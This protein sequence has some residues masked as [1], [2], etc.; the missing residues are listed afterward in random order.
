MK[1]NDITALHGMTVG[2]LNK[3]LLEL[4]TQVAKAKLEKRVNRLPN[5]KL[6]ST[7][8]KDIAR[9]KTVIT[10]KAMVEKVATKA[11]V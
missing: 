6:V 11:K 4:V 10:E 2:D 9:I 3:K 8:R 7:V 5:R 1:R